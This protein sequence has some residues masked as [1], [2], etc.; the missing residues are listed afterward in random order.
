VNEA[1]YL[2]KGLG[3]TEVKF[4]HVLAGQRKITQ[5]LISVVN[6]I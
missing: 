6:D 5:G 2:S 4:E 1:I 3:E